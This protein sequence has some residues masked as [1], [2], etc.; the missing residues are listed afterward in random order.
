VPGQH[1]VSYSLSQPLKRVLAEIV[2]LRNSFEQAFGNI[3]CLLLIVSN[4]SVTRFDRWGS[5]I[6]RPA[7]LATD[8]VQPTRG[9]ELRLTG[10][11]SIAS[12]LWQ[13]L[14]GSVTSRVV[15]Y[16]EQHLL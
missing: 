1:R 12:W 4:L 14:R 8:A 15:P 16:I 2:F 3:L 10:C 13:L 6:P 11:S 9:G 5:V 7:V